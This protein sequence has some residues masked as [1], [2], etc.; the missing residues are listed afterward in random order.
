MVLIEFGLKASIKSPARITPAGLRASILAYG[1][2]E[3]SLE[4]RITYRHPYKRFVLDDEDNIPCR[5][6][7][8]V[9]GPDCLH[10]GASCAKGS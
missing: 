7:I 4:E 9:R 3:T 2:L 1:R 8:E 10:A 6:V 5:P